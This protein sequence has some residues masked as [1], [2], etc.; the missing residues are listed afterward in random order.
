MSESRVLFADDVTSLAGRYGKQ[1]A[2]S[3]HEMVTRTQYLERREELTVAAV[4]ESLAA[5]PERLAEWLEYSA[6][7]RSKGGWYIRAE[8]GCVEVGH[9]GSDGRVAEKRSYADLE[10]ACAEF[11]LR[12][13]E[14]IAHG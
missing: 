10:E 14:Q 13:L 3:I 4:R 6:D 9:L 2:L 8:H 1:E 12:E 5:S 7:K 11:I